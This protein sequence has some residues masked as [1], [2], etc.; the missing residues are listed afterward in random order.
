[1]TLARILTKI[2]KRIYFSVLFLLFFFSFFIPQNIVWAVQNVGTVTG[3]ALDQSTNP[4]DFGCGILCNVKVYDNK[5]TGYFF[6]STNDGAGFFV[7]LDPDV[8]WAVE[9]DGNGNLIGAGYSENLGTFIFHSYANPNI[10]VTIN[11][12]T[13]EFSGYAYNDN[14]GFIHFEC[15]N[16]MGPACVKTTWRKA[17][18]VNGVC[19]TANKTY[20]NPL[21]MSYGSDTFCATGVNPNPAPL[22]PTIQTSAT[23]VC[24]GQSGGSPSPSCKAQLK[25]INLEEDPLEQIN[26]CT[27]GNTQVCVSAPNICGNTNS[28][29]QVCDLN[30]NWG[31][32]NV[33][34]P[35]NNSCP[36]VGECIV[37]AIQVCVSAPNSCGNTNSGQRTCNNNAHWNACTVSIPS[38]IS[39]S[40]LNPADPNLPNNENQNQANKNIFEVVNTLDKELITESLKNILPEETAQQVAIVVS[41]PTTNFVST[42]MKVVGLALGSS[43]SAT[44]VLAV[45]PVAASNLFLLPLQIWNVI[46]SLLGIRSKQKRWGVVYDS[47]TLQPL[48]PVYVVLKDN[49]GKEVATSITDLDG[50][51]GFQ[52]KT[53]GNYKIF[54]NKGDYV[55]PSVK[56]AGKTEDILYKDLYFGA[57]ILIKEMGEVITKN[58]PM[59]RLNFNWN[60]WEKNEHGLMKFYKKRDKWIVLFSNIFFN[61]GF[62]VTGVTAFLSPQLFNFIV[63]GFYVLI[64]VA[65]KTSFLKVKK[66][67]SVTKN[68]GSPFSFAIL[69]FYAVSMP[70]RELAHTV[71]DKFGRYYRLLSNG[72][73]V[74]K[75]EE[76]IGEDAYK[77]VFTSEVINVTKGLI[78]NDFKV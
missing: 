25:I 17:I 48:D 51:Y 13:G 40:P 22:F 52:V 5:L 34:P 57:D 77:L 56:L 60:E 64:F 29:H 67:G 30:G 12:N 74:V 45:A 2:K 8:S 33:L 9:N 76:K 72:S 75:I 43:T 54:A 53:P 38:D 65:R 62:L 70:E 71:T 66:S 7:Q 32:C 3:T 63:F 50:R 73:Y 23:W 44:A 16:G 78:Q 21:V 27:S 4:V 41:H 15:V 1:M 35:S 10:M 31:E 46:L 24:G 28:G 14:I 37:G 58:I 55:F 69:R 19:G 18:P 26:N 61:L 47:V 49:Q 36:P 11:P 42:S 68:D 59:D 6:V 39:C 20:N